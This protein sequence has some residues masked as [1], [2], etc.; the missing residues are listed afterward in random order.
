MVFPFSSSNGPAVDQPDSP[1]SRR[2]FLA[3]GVTAVAAPLLLSAC[4]SSCYSKSG[5]AAAACSAEI[6][7]AQRIRAEN[8]PPG[9]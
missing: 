8:R 1:A 5:E 2:R 6:S 4:N 3:L 9:R 7:A